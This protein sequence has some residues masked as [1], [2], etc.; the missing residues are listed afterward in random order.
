MDDNLML[1]ADQKR[2]RR[3]VESQGQVFSDDPAIVAAAEPVFFAIQGI[4]PGFWECVTLQFSY[5]GAEQSVE[6]RDEDGISWKDVTPDAGT[7]Y[8][9]GLSHEATEQGFEYA[10]M[11]AMHEMCHVLCDIAGTCKIHEHDQ[12]F[13]G[14]LD[15]L[16]KRFN[17][18][19]GLE[20]KNDYFGLD[21]CFDGRKNH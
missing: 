14:V 2:L 11:V 5:V 7:L 13:H 19:T 12:H 15:G 4:F 1:E 20:V 17:T 10:A 9:V 16:I 6:H 8:A 3:W 18:Q 21:S